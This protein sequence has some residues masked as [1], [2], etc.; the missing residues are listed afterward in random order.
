MIAFEKL[1][2]IVYDR[3]LAANNKNRG[4]IKGMASPAGVAGAGHSNI[5][6]HEGADAS[7]GA[8]S[9]TSACG[10]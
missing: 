3:A 5:K 7:S 10:Y 1:I 6:L 8:D 2:G 9:S 4:G